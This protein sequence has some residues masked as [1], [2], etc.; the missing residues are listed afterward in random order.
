M[1]FLT[2]MLTILSISVT[3]FN[4]VVDVLLNADLDDY[5][6]IPYAA[7]M[8]DG[9][10]VDSA[11]YYQKNGVNYTF[12]TTINTGIVKTYTLY[13]EA[14]F[15]AYDIRDVAEITFNVIDDVAPKITRVPVF[16]MEVGDDPPDLSVGFLYDDNY[17]HQDGLIVYID[18]F[19]VNYHVIGIYDITYRVIDS[20]YNETSAISTI[21]I[22]DTVCPSIQQTQPI[23]IERKDTSSLLR[24]FTISDTYDLSPQVNID[25]SHID[26]STVGQYPLFLNAYDQSGNSSALE[27]TLNIVDTTAPNI[28]LTSA[29][30]PITVYDETALLSLKDYIIQIDDS[31]DVMTHEDVII[32]HDINIGMLGKYQV[33][34][35][36]KDDYDNESTASLTVHVI[37]NIMPTITLIDDLIFDVYS[38]EPFYESYFIFS[39]NYDL[40]TALNITVNTHP[41]FDEIGQYPI[42]I[43]ASD[44]SKNLATY[45]GYIYIVDHEPPVV[46]QV[47]DLIVTDFTV[48]MFDN[49]FKVTDN[50]DT[51]SNLMIE[52][53]D[54]YVDYRTLGI[55]QVE[56]IV[57]DRSLN[58]TY[59]ET[60]LFIVDVKSPTITLSQTL[61][62]LPVGSE[63]F[64]LSHYITSVSDDYDVLNIDD[65][66]IESDL[67]VTKV[68]VYEI[69]YIATDQSG[70]IT[71]ATLQITVDDFTAPVIVLSDMAINQ[72]A[73]FDIMTGVSVIETAST[74]QI[75]SY[76]SV[77]NTDEPGEY[78]ITYIAQDARG[79]YQTATRI[80]TITPAYKPYQITDFIPMIVV[81]LSGSIMIY[82]IKKNG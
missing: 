23:V 60:D 51:S 37:D 59:I 61:V 26:F 79:N 81:V 6:N 20:S 64:E 10:I 11:V 30:K 9:D 68:G 54:D 28:R 45:R 40:M 18:D 69:H 75:T 62:T 2:Q 52:I 13:Y 29:P 15:P 4:T 47:S 8:V 7:L 43:T 72:Y 5:L 70:N 34:F 31:G 49:Y 67:D 66:L 21:F 27:T 55:Y 33:Y 63:L 44:K 17:D 80:L 82:A 14:Y 36:V 65:V 48:H 78:I 38:I 53:N 19:G 57:T 24:Y 22:V 1:V 50:Y 76:P 3:W 16:H 74:Y 73:S 42:E 39:D 41:D 32:T 12:V 25:T 56:V 46:M 35:K 71:T 77:I 58:E